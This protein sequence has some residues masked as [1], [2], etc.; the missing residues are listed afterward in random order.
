V[1]IFMEQNEIAD[2]GTRHEVENVFRSFLR[3]RSETENWTIS[4]R[5]MA[6]SYEIRAAGPSQTR[7][8]L[9]FDD[10]SSLPEKVRVWLELYPLT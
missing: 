2:A 4:I 3:N 5:R 1:A 10:D 9:F 8:K 6:G 7:E